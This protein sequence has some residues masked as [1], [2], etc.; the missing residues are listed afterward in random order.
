MTQD[1]PCVGNSSQAIPE[2]IRR[3]VAAA[4]VEPISSLDNLTN[5]AADNRDLQSAYEA[6]VSNVIC[7]RLQR[8][9]DFRPERYPNSEEYYQKNDKK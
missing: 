5:E 7:H 4:G 6:Q 9:S 2:S 3:A 8:D 1:R